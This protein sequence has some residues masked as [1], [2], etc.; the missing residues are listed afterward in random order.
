M[1]LEK[2]QGLAVDSAVSASESLTAGAKALRINLDQKIF[3]TF[4]EIGAGQE[5]AR[6]FFRVGGAAGTIA[7]TMSA[8]DMTFS[9][10][11]YGKAGRYVSRERL[12]G[13]L[14]HEYRLLLERLSSKRGAQS[15]FFVFANTVAARSFKGG[16][17]CHGWM[18]V[19]FQ[20]EPLQPPNDII[21]HVR[22]TD[23]ANVLQQQAIGIIGVNLLYGAFFQRMDPDQFIQG[24]L[25][26]L[27]IDRIE[28][29][30]I[31]FTG[32]DV[33]KIDN[34]LMSLRLVQRG[35]TNAAM[36]APDGSV[37]QPSEVLHHRPILVERGSFRPVTHVNLD[38]IRCA[39]ERF[40]QDN[41]GNDP[42]TLFEITLHNLLSSG[43]LD[44]ADFLERADTVSTL[45]QTVLI[46]NY[47]EYYR[48]ISYFLRYTS[49]SIGVVM[50][51]NSLMQIFNEDYYHDL[52]G[53]MLEALGRLFRQKVRLYVYP[54]G[55][56]AYGEFIRGTP[57]EAL[58]REVAELPDI[59]SARDVLIQPHLRHLYAYSVEAGRIAA[60]ENFNKDYL[61]IFSRDVLRKLQSGDQSWEAGVP[62][63][64]AHVIR[65]RSM[66]GYRAEKV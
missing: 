16:Q 20:T 9:D 41:A 28:V 11:I 24:L 4:A 5:V 34:R 42:V 43:N 37:L 14:N 8:Y 52:E 17:D 12:L 7:K 57:L 25:D 35:L 19:R 27:S 6:H 50:G 10:E 49:E 46:S 54:M 18:G 26:E 29:D 63:P 61:S 59:V 56:R 55:K 38:M 65:S 30:M 44:D 64:A 21:L 51:T 15:T 48:L 40:L 13:M 3:G 58:E 53:G 62:A 45:G 47:S 32:P 1:D 2:E 33:K 66:F 22:M 39:R 31:E 60:L 36:F 23:K